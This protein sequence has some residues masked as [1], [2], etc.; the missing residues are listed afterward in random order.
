MRS[1]A[2]MSITGRHTCRC[3]GLPP[4]HNSPF[5]LLVNIECVDC[6][7]GLMPKYIWYNNFIPIK[8]FQIQVHGV[9]HNNPM[10]VV[11]MKQ[12]DKDRKMYPPVFEGYVYSFQREDKGWFRFQLEETCTER[13][14]KR[15][16][17]SQ[18]TLYNN[19]VNGKPNQKQEFFDLVVRLVA[20]TA[21]G[22]Q[23]RIQSHVAQKIICRVSGLIFFGMKENLLGRQSSSIHG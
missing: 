14:V 22:N 8:E 17:F 16:H 9:R 20:V 5:Q 6:E 10:S 13:I 4:C 23:Y 2:P 11:A 19:Q 7:A 18:A 21:D 15:L 12:S 3:G 1:K